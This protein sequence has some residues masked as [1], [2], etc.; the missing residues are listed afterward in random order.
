MVRRV[1][2]NSQAREAG[3]WTQQKQEKNFFKGTEGPS[4]TCEIISRRK[5]I[6][7]IVTLVFNNRKNPGI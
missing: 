1:L 4:W 5:Q 2:R 3:S 7:P 6:S